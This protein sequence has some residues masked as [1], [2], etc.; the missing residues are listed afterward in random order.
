MGWNTKYL[1]CVYQ[2]IFGRFC[3][4]CKQFSKHFQKFFNFLKVSSSSW[5]S[6]E[7][8]GNVDLTRMKP[9]KVLKQRLHTN[10]ELCQYSFV[11]SQWT[12]TLEAI[13]NQ[14]RSRQEAHQEADRGAD[15]ETPGS[16]PEV[17]LLPSSR[18]I[19]MI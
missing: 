8:S 9:L 19:S 1:L 16:Q 3:Q 5:R 13:A 12:P 11:L 17:D 2:H 18:F 7:I 4:R 10:K 15:W 14:P 6:V